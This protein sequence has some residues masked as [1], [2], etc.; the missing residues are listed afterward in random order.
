MATYEKWKEHFAR[1]PETSIKKYQ[2]AIDVLLKDKMIK[3]E[4]GHDLN[5]LG[6]LMNNA[7]NRKNLK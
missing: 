6:I 4:Y 7:I 5:T 1:V 3:E 2:R